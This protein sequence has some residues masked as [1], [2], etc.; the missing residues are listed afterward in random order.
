MDQDQ[1]A[2]AV[3][4]RVNLSTSLMTVNGYLPLANFS[5]PAVLARKI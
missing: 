5:E 3:T 4:E 2:K 1:L